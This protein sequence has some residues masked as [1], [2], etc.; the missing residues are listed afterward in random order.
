MVLTAPL[1]WCQSA[2]TADSTLAIISV[3]GM[4]A[5]VT[6][7]FRPFFSRDTSASLKDL[8]DKLMTQLVLS[9]KNVI[10]VNQKLISRTKVFQ[11]SL[12]TVFGGIKDSLGVGSDLVEYLRCVLC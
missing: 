7:K 4:F 1:L 12:L 8:N 2:K 3:A 5:G 11:T 9:T 10:L 6:A